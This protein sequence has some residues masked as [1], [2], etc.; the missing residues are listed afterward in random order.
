MNAHIMH[1]LMHKI[2]SI[3][4]HLPTIELNKEF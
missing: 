4:Q 1:A 3:S 2:C